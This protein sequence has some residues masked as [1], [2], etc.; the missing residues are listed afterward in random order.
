M[1]ASIVLRGD[2]GAGKGVVVNALAEVLGKQYFYHVHDAEHSIFGRFTPKNFEQCLLLFVDEAVWGGCRAAAGKLKKIVTEDTHDIENKY[3]ARF[4]I[5]SYMNVIFASNEDWV[6]P[7][8][9]KAR[10]WCCLDVSNTRAG[11]GNAG[12]FDAI[13]AVPTSVLA[14]F[15]HRR[16]ITTFNPRDV[17]STNMLRDQKQRRFSLAVQWWEG[18]L[19]K[20]ILTIGYND[21]E[22]YGW[23]E[24]TTPIQTQDLHDAYKRHYKDVSGRIEG[25]EMFIKELNKV[26]RLKDCRPRG[27][28]GTRSHAKLIPSLEECRHQFCEKVNDPSWFSRN[29]ELL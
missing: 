25:V 9:Y 26:C 17:P 28:S 12:Y 3:G 16:D 24:P 29:D 4:Q 20:G 2:E 21:N 18:C 5:P 1:G 11:T 8:G 14:A 19:S 6:I 22:S 23:P 15:L 10:R 13:R 7:A 27:K